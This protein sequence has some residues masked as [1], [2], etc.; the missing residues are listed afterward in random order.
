MPRLDG[1]GPWWNQAR[2]WRCHGASERA[3]GWR[4]QQKQFRV[5]SFQAKDQ[6]KK[7]LEDELKELEFEQQQIKKRL[8][9]LE[10]KTT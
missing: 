6:Q 3:P 5:T 4:W 7:I 8:T 10:E 2:I 1:T 9:E